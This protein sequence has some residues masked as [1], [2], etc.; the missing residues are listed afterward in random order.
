[1]DPFNFW[2]ALTDVVGEEKQAQLTAGE[3]VLLTVDADG[4]NPKTVKNINRRK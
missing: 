2:L 1:M 4:E 3:Q